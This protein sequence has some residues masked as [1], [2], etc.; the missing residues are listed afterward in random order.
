MDFTEGVEQIRSEYDIPL[1][2]VSMGK[3]G[4][5]AYYKDKI[6]K[7]APFLQENTIETTGAGDT[8]CGCIL[9]Y[10]L[11]WGLEDLTE[12]QLKEM[13]TF[14]NAAASI[15][16]TRKG[17]LC[18]MP[19]KEEVEHRCSVYETFKYIHQYKMLLF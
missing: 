14:A 16:T 19:T 10:V 9:H 12:E 6:V 15:I 7:A 1:I 8:F 11:Q 18:V 13:L 4:S 3:E 2:L 17:A 5:L